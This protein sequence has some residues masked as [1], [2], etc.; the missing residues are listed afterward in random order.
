[1]VDNLPNNLTHLTFGCEFD[2]SVNSLPN[3]IKEL[4]YWSNSKINNISNNV[5]YIN[6]QFYKNDKY[7]EVIDV[8]PLNIKEIR[9]NYRDKA[10]YL[11]KI[12]FGCKIMDENENEIF[13]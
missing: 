12:P 8:L 4:T 6:I 11:K 13:I 10:H 3:S 1:L 5:E 9:I 2:Q 7:N